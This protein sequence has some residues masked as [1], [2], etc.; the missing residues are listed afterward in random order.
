MRNKI[1][2]FEIPTYIGNNDF[3]TPSA[4][5]LFALISFLEKKEGFCSETNEYLASYLRV[6]VRTIARSI[7]LL[8]DWKYIEI[9]R[10]RSKYRILTLNK[11]MT[12]YKEAAKEV[13]ELIIQM[14]PMHDQV[15]IAKDIFSNAL[16]K[17]KKEKK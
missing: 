1:S 17:Y 5:K 3:I 9:K 16:D 6:E 12:K 7:K 8:E 15:D 14:L 10:R 11:D 2:V 13:D 4:C